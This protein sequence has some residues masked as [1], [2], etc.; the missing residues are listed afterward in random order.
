M[1]IVRRGSLILSGSPRL[2]RRKKNMSNVSIPCVKLCLHLNYDR[3]P[4][5]LAGLSSFQLRPRRHTLTTLC[6]ATVAAMTSR[7]PLR[8]GASREQPEKAATCAH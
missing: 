2:R 5:D 7:R 8:A 6:R 1:E 4:A 3:S